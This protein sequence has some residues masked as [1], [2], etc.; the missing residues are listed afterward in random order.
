MKLHYI[1][2]L[3]PIQAYEESAGDSAEQ[4]KEAFRAQVVSTTKSWL[5]MR[6]RSYNFGIVHFYPFCRQVCWSG[7]CSTCPHSRSM[8]ASPGFMTMGP[9]VVQ[10][11]NTSRNSGDSTLSWKRTCC[12][13]VSVCINCT[14]Q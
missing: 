3:L 9:P 14:K 4:S 12:R 10:S 7:A 5:S 11:S 8:A 1:S 2:R 6:V 13:C